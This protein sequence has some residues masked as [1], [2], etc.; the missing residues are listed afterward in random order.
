MVNGASICSHPQCAK[1][2]KV[3]GLLSAEFNGP[4]AKICVNKMTLVHI[5]M[6]GG[7]GYVQIQ[8]LLSAHETVTDTV[9]M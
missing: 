5:F 8:H 6:N 4:F 9:F 2:T 7:V 1:S 3:N